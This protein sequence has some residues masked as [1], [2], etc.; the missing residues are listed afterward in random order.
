MLA[1]YGGY[2]CW[3]EVYEYL[4]GEDVYLDTAFTLKYI[5]EEMFMKILHKHDYKKILFASDIPWS[6]A[7]QDVSI[8]A[9]MPLEEQVRDAILSGNA[10]RLLGMAGVV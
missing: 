8:L 5:S 1:H 3:E 9:A 4:A 2:D 7:R 10:K 6:D